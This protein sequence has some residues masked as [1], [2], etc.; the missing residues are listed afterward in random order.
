MNISTHS[1]QGE[2]GL[3]ASPETWLTD[4]QPKIEFAIRPAMCRVLDVAKIGGMFPPQVPSLH[5]N[6]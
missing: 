3:N 1:V 5:E 2:T 6:S 4:F